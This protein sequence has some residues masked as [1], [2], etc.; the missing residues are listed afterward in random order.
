MSLKLVTV[1]SFSFSS[2]LL[3]SLEYNFVQ[4]GTLH[5]FFFFLLQMFPTLLS[6]Y[7]LIAQRAA[8]LF[9]LISCFFNLPGFCTSKVGSVWLRRSFRI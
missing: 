3:P 4:L 5:F 8:L 7:L 1:S 2:S 9:L 6:G